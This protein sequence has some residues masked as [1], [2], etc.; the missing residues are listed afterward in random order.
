MIP[1]QYNK[2]FGERLQKVIGER[3]KVQVA[4]DLDCSD[5]T[6]RMWLKGKVPFAIHMLKKLHDV[7]GA[8]LNELIAGK[9][10]TR[11]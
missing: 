5:V 6:V 7:Y 10:R 8:D 1:T 11:N 9:K 2:E 3:S 4:D